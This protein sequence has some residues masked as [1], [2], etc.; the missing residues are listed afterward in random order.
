MR[1]QVSVSGDGGSTT[2]IE[3]RPR[4]APPPAPPRSFL[5]ERG[6]FD[7]AGTWIGPR[8]KAAPLLAQARTSPK[9]PWGR[10][11]SIAL[12]QGASHLPP[13][14]S[15]WGRAGEGGGPPSRT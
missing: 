7:P 5:T 11:T 14:R 9:N 4:G 10:W 6:E 12:R 3:L 15:L 8:S 13:P 1:R 2:E